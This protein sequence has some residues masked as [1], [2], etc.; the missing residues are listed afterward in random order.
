MN[1]PVIVPVG[2][3]TQSD[4]QQIKNA[5]LMWK[6]FGEIKYKKQQT[7]WKT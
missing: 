7:E 5:I 2:Y 6:E 3:L 1:F 4:S